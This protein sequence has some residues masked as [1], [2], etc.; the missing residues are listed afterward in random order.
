MIND[1]HQKTYRNIQIFIIFFFRFL[2]IS[3]NFKLMIHSTCIIVGK[4]YIR[5]IWNT[6]IAYI[7]AAY[8]AF[9]NVDSQ[10]VSHDTF[11]NI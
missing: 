1:K 4:N 3:F 6:N 7:S 11:L 2:E 9:Y 5:F 10:T 8:S